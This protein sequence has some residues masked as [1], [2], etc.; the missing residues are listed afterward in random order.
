M[1]DTLLT[2]DALWFSVPALVGT[3]VF[4]VRVLAMFFGGG[5]VDVSDATSH[6]AGHQF[7]IFSVHSAL[8][9]AMGFGWGGLGALKGSGASLPVSMLV[10]VG[11]GVA[12]LALLGYVMASMQRLAQSGNLDIESLEGKQGEVT[13]TVPA[14]SGRGEVKVLVGQRERRAWAVSASGQIAVRTRIR[15]V[16]VNQDNTVT[17]APVD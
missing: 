11:C 9:F 14:G 10:G 4:V 6:S 17:V 12:M 7:E 1:L 8:A 5:D 2:G 16:K 13:A 3:L 15:V